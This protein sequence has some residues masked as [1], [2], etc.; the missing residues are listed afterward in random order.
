MDAEVS[1]PETGIDEFSS[2][3]SGQ[4]CYP[5]GFGGIAFWTYFRQWKKGS[6]AQG[7]KLNLFSFTD[8]EGETNHGS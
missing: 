6:D 5:H 1:A 4:E 8:Y 2:D 7:A 3:F